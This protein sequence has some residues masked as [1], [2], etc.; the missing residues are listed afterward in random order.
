MKF[1]QLIE[2]N[3]RNIFLEKSYTK[4]GRETITKPFSKK[5]KLSISLCTNRS[6]V[7]MRSQALYSIYTEQDTLI[8]SRAFRIGQPAIWSRA[9]GIGHPAVWS[10]AFGAGHPAIWSKAIQ[11]RSTSYTDQGNQSRIS[12]YVEQSIW[13][14]LVY[15]YSVTI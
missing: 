15:K 1:I 11:G 10:R 8:Q 12:C 5:S 2:Y 9:F 7:F 3:M 14:R 4:C 6:S 13:S